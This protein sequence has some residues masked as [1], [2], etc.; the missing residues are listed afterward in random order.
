LT[1]EE[2]HLS[3]GSEVKALMK[4]VKHR[5][6]ALRDVKRMLIAVNGEFAE[7]EDVLAEGDMVA[8]FPPVSGG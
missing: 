6:E 2:F 5:H 7:P 3:Q 4:V 8:L 1:E